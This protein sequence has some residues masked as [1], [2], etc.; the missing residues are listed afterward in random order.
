M[1]Q[2]FLLIALVSLLGV[3]AESANA[4]CDRNRLSPIKCGYHDEGHQDGVRDAENNSSKTYTRYRSK[5]ERQY[6]TFYR[7]GYNTGY[8]S[9]NR[10][11]RWTFAERA[12]YDLGYGYGENDRRSSRTSSPQANASRSAMNVRPYFSQGYLDGYSGTSKRYDFEIGQNP[13]GG[14]QNP[15]D[16]SV[17]WRGRIDNTVNITISGR[18]VTAR[19]LNGQ[20][21]SAINFDINGSLPRRQGTVVAVNI[22]DGR[23]TARV[24]QQPS[25]RNNYTAIIQVVDSRAGADNYNLDITW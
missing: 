16:G 17:S 22:R 12:A 9:V 20:A 8:D 23:G 25:S 5:Y 19:A 24:I 21:P 18:R 15:Q 11:R 6:E 7:D 3:F 13:G 10:G 4:Q 1:K 14:W 2:I